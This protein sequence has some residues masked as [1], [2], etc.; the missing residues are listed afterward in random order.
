MC[1]PKIQKTEMICEKEAKW[2]KAKVPNISVH[3][4]K[5]EEEMQQE[6]TSTKLMVNALLSRIE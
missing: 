3:L 5:Q 1:K 2:L 6:L 4:I